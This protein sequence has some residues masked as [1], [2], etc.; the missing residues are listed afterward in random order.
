MQLN[1]RT[2]DSET[3]VISVEQNDTVESVKLK[4]QDENIQL[5]YLG[6]LLENSKN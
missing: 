3:V 6:M 1:I 4:I 2:L 5:Y